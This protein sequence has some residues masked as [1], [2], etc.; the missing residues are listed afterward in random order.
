MG[1]CDLS[2]YLFTFTAAPPLT[3]QAFGY[4]LVHSRRKFYRLFPSNDLHALMDGHVAA[5]E[6]FQGAALCR[7]NCCAPNS[8]SS[9]GCNRACPTC[10]SPNV[11]FTTEPEHSEHLLID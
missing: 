2:P 7:A 3:L 11:V 10:H 4:V 5:F 8:D 1:E 9:P 6:R